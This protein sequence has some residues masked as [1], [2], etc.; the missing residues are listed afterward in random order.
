[1]V[2]EEPGGGWAYCLPQVLFTK[3]DT[4]DSEPTPQ[5]RG[6]DGNSFVALAGSS[7]L[8]QGAFLPK[9]GAFLQ[10]TR[11]SHRTSRETSSPSVR[12]GPWG[13]LP[14]TANALGDQAHGRQPHRS[15]RFPW[16]HPVAPVKRCWPLK[17][18]LASPPSKPLLILFQAVPYPK[19]YPPKFFVFFF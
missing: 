15:K 5:H 8:K 19:L 12:P 18:A 9:Q 6:K 14:Y 4:A 17:S 1:M 3:G 7:L 10:E 13:T 11:Q 16:L 2:L